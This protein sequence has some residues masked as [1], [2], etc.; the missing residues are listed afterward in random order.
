MPTEAEARD[1]IAKV[2]A[3]A[4]FAD[5]ARQYS[6]DLSATEGG[7]IGYVPIDALSA[8]VGAVLFALSPG[9]VTAYPVHALPRYFVMQ[10][11]GR[12]QRS[13]PTF[14]AARPVLTSELR[15]EAA[16]A[17]ICALT[18]DIKVKDAGGPAKVQG[19]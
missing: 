8:E 9:Q 5:L 4:D 17:A 6:K 7:D 19:Q 11:E 15:Q 13:T 10:V 14:D 2:Q 18:A 16:A 12:R 3:G 1:V